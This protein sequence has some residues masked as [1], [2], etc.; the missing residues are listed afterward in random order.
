MKNNRAFILLCLLFVCASMQPSVNKKP[1]LVQQDIFQNQN[2]VVNANDDRIEMF[3]N[4]SWFAPVLNNDY[5][6][7][8][9]VKSVTITRSPRFGKAEV[10]EDFTIKYTPD[11]NFVGL[12]DFEYRVCNIYDNCGIAVVKAEVRNFDFK[13]IAVN[14][15]VKI[16]D[17]S[18]PEIEVLANDLF[19]YDLP[20]AIT[21]TTNLNF[22][23][24]TV[25]PNNNI[26]PEF[27]SFFA[28]TDSLEY[29]VCDAEG[30]CAKAWV[31]IIM[32][33]NINHKFNIPSGFSPNGDE[34]NNTFFIP[35]FRHFPNS[36]IKIIDRNGNMVYEN[37]E[38]EN[39]WDGVGN[40]GNYNGKPAPRGTYYY[41]IRL[42]G[43]KK[44][45]TG[46]VYLNR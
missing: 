42:K 32:G 15:T 18:N 12:D 31:F 6:L 9:G 46:F 33:D 7:A 23:S 28:G 4:S 8:D 10:M 35:E 3:E 17:G 24:S 27:E 45:L 41:L 21:I 30:D 29:K 44:E 16:S 1:G 39:N 2:P 26:I 22:G 37:S 34:F 20:V 19:I 43:L 38:Y 25:T 5:G 36:Y 14:D 13:P 40:K 11:F